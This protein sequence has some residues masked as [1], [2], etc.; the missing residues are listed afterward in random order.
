[1]RDPIE[2]YR[3]TFYPRDCDHMGHVNVVSYHFRFDEACW[4]TYLALGITPSRMRA[5]ELNMAAVRQTAD[6][7]RELFSGD[8]VTIR[9]RVVELREKVIRFE[10]EMTND[11]TGDVAAVSEYTVV[12]LD[13]ATRR[14][15]AF[16]PDVAERA[17][18]LLQA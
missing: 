15:R 17:R 7:K 12:C 9:T 3:G 2:T 5:Q 4:Q 1:M 13:P 8:C 14:A 18:A 11:E 6:F 16:P 10:H